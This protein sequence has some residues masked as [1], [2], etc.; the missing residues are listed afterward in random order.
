MAS[1]KN[2]DLTSERLYECMLCGM[3]ARAPRSMGCPNCGGE[4]QNLSTPRE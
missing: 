1:V 2:E 4:M 3:R